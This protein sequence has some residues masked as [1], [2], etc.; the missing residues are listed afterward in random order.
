MI[1]GTLRIIVALPDSHSLKEKR[2]VVKGLKERLHAK[3]NIAV[4]ETEFLDMWQKAELGIVAVGNETPHVHSMLDTVLKYV[5]G[6]PE[7]AVVDVE[8]EVMPA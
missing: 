5:R 1:V 8:H 4:A 2:R 6:C 7:V 3:F